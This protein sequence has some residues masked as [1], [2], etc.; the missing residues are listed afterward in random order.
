MYY[1]LTIYL[2]FI[3]ISLE[4]LLPLP[5]GRVMLMLNSENCAAALFFPGLL[6]ALDAEPLW[7]TFY[8]HLPFQAVTLDMIKSLPH[9]CAILHIAACVSLLVVSNERHFFRAAKA[10]AKWVARLLVGPI[11]L[12]VILETQFAAWPAL[13]VCLNAEFTRHGIIMAWLAIAASAAGAIE[14]SD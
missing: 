2:L 10:A 4:K 7:T 14:K 5:Y 6:C 8:F 9:I 1:E 13:A 3:G 12:R 11:S